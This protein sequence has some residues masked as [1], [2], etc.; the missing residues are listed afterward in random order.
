V[1]TTLGLEKNV[2]N[3]TL[4]IAC[5]HTNIAYM[6]FQLLFHHVTL[7]TGSYSYTDILGFSVHIIVPFWKYF[8]HKWKC[9]TPF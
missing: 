2:S 4:V 3:F 5:L 1:I 9:I 6:W 7:I 8:L